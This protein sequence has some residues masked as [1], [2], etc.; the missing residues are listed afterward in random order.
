MTAEE[1]YNF[2]NN[3]VEAWHNKQ[4]QEAITFF[5]QAVE[6]AN[7]VL[8]QDTES[9]VKI[10]DGFIDMTHINE[11]LT[12][13]FFIS[14]QKQEVEILLPKIL[15]GLSL[16]YS[17]LKEYEKGLST[18]KKAIKLGHKLD[19]T[20]S[21]SNYGFLCGMTGNYDD[22]LVYLNKSIQ[23][24]NNNQT[25]FV[26]RGNI[27]YLIS[28]LDHA[29][30]DY[31]TAIQ[32]NSKNTRAFFNRGEIYHI[33][34]RYSF[35]HSDW[36]RLIYLNSDGIIVKYFS[37]LTAFF[38]DISPAPYVVRQL[39]EKVPEAATM[40]SFGGLWVQTNEQCKAI[41]AYTL[42][43]GQLK[44][45]EQQ[46]P[47]AYHAL[48][49]Y[50]HYLMGTVGE[51]FEIFD[52]ILDNQLKHTFS[53]REHY[54]YLQSAEAFQE[55]TENLQ[56]DALEVAQAYL[57][58]FEV[59]TAH[60]AQQAELYYAGLLFFY[61]GQ[62]E[63][64]HHCF[65]RI[66]LQYPPAAYMQV[67][68]LEKLGRREDLGKK[69]TRIR[70]WEAS[71]PQ[72]KYL[73]GFTIRALS[74]ENDDFLEPI[75]DYLIYVELIEAIHLVR[76]ADDVPFQNPAFWEAFTL[77]DVEIQRVNIDCL[78]LKL[79]ALE[80][81]FSINT[82]QGQTPRW[83]E[84]QAE[85]NFEELKTIAANSEVLENTIAEFITK[86]DV[87][88]AYYTYYIQYFYVQQKLGLMA[89]YSLY[90]YLNF[91]KTI[92]SKLSDN[93]STGLEK[94]SEE[95]LKTALGSGAVYFLASTTGYL[96]IPIAVIARVLGKI[97]AKQINEYQTSHFDSELI[98]YSRIK[99]EIIASLCEDVGNQ[100]QE[101]HEFYEKYI[102]PELKKWMGKKANRNSITISCPILR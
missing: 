58:N 66:F 73:N 32:I 51:A 4:F 28:N 27:Y 52:E 13:Q 8:Q 55:P 6:S 29:I 5:D 11:K 15:Y 17:E 30:A 36:I 67:L 45:A 50:T 18:F 99:Q 80:K 9:V 86:W 47:A 57:E 76:Q 37:K 81:D 95:V 87:K 72:P 77:T 38:Q 69:I 91:Y 7:E 78:M 101:A 61:A 31:T 59:S 93:T 82:T 96:S 71:L 41:D 49:A 23:L 46:Q 39:F 48:R 40:Y 25:A 62:V 94:L 54:Y 85:R 100:P 53:L 75:Y 90:N 21:C 88:P 1:C 19:N 74:L 3:G 63:Q 33:L 16:T 22:A 14:N 97:F 10:I 70:Q 68:T 12:E 34:E 44:T 65:T 92:K 26:N 102:L 79:K 98:K 35:V 24:D 84:L 56:R 83:N 89:V 43:V 42:H 64:A 20:T 2:Y 60:I